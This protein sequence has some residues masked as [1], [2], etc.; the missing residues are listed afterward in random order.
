MS[1][2]QSQP[3]AYFKRPAT[4]RTVGSGERTLLLMILLTLSL[5]GAI[6]TRLGY[7]QLIEG[8][9]NQQ[10]ANENRIR[11]IPKRPERGKLLDRKGRILAH[12]RFSYSV[13]VW[14]M[15]LRQA[16]WPQTRAIVAEI[17]NLPED[18]IQERLEQAGEYS[19]TLVRIAQALPFDQVV[20]LAERS[21]EL[22]GVEI[23]QE[24]VRDYPHG[25]LA[26][27]VLG[28]I[29]EIS[30][31]ELDRRQDEGYRLGDIVGQMGIEAAY[32]SQ[33][34]GTWGGQQVE[35]DGSGRI[36]QV[37]GEKPSLPGKNVTLSLDLEVQ[38]A[39]EAALGDR[40]GAV[41]AI[42]P[43]NGEVLAM[44]SRPGFDPNWFARR[45]TEAEWQ[46]LQSRQF[47]FVNRALQGFPPASTFKVVTAIAGLE[48]DT[49]SPDTILMTYPSIHGVGD[50]NG[51][52]FG[53][54]GF[55][56]AM[57]WSSNTF[58]GQV[59][60]RTGP[61]L[62]LEWAKKLGLGLPTGIDIQGESAGFLPDPAWKEEVF[63]YGW[64][65]AD[66]VMV[67]IGQ[68]AVQVSPLQ[69][70]MVYATIANGGYRVKPHLLRAAT[71]QPEWQPV[72]LNLKPSTLNVI[73]NGLRAVVT[74]GTGQALNV[75]S[76]PPAAGKSGTGEDPP[77]R[78]HTWFG[79]YAPFNNPEIVVVAFGENTGGGGGSVAGPMTLQ[80][81]E[82]YFKK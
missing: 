20:A 18:E 5:F 77:R 65:P 1:L 19:P 21:Y 17:L 27:Q 62:F 67:S 52:G 78:S 26:A 23:D 45:V 58:F 37:L 25:E 59:G 38:R 55:V 13:F 4:S 30:A 68:G 81:L 22:P 3:T 71:E 73:R 75:P 69:A 63:G 48:S 33:L 61:T 34:R 10:L 12:S 2:L 60:V 44:A 42:D 82:A 74:S 16:E 70:A 31:E 39:A 47:P 36:V 49:F 57:Q 41:V 35:V 43:R 80:V 28:Y 54:I 7:L 46:Q 24:A 9:R 79:A 56:T 50:W 51:A 72:P 11:L 15:V 76:I 40:Q 6:G 8:E 32:E 66:S 29:G 14:P 53:A 64:Y